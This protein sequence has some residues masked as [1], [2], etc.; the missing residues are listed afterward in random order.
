MKR[1]E[2]DSKTKI[3]VPGPAARIFISHFEEEYIGVEMYYFKITLRDDVIPTIF[4]KITI[5]SR[6]CFD[7]SLLFLVSYLLRN[8]LTQ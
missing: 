7:I 2:K 5:K 6:D 1:L 8:Y 3:F 4:Y